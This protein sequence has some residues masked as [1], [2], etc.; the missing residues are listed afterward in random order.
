MTDRSDLAPFLERVV[1]GVGLWVVLLGFVGSVIAWIGAWIPVVGFTTAL[2]SAAVAARLAARLPAPTGRPLGPV[3]AG[4]LVVGVLAVTVWTGVTHSEQVLPRR[5]SASYLQATI[6]LAEEG[7]RPVSVDAGT[8]GGPETLAE[9]GLTLEAPAFYE[10]GSPE[11]PQVQPQFMPGPALVYSLPWW[12]GGATPTLWT[13]AVAGGLAL[14]AVGMLVAR[15]VGPSAAAPA[16]VLVGACFPWLHT[17]RSTY[18]EPLAGLTLGAGFLA[19]TLLARSAEQRTGGE[20]TWGT[21][22]VVAGALIGG[23]AI[24]R[25]DALRETMLLIPV[26]ALLLARGRAWARPLLVGAVGTTLAGFAV[27]GVMSWRYLGEIGSSLVPLVALVVLMSLVCWWL[28][29]RARAGWSVPRPLTQRLP[30]LLAGAVLVVGVALSLRPLFMTV[31]QDPSDPGAMYVA[32]MQ[33][34]LGLPIDGGRTYAEHSVDWLAWWIGPAALVIALV[35]LAVLAHRLGTW[36]AKGGPLPAWGPALIVVTGSTLLTLVRPGIT[37]DH[38]WADRRLLIALPLALVL[39]V[40]AAWWAGGQASRRWG[41]AAGAAVLV[42]LL[43][44]TAVPTAAATWPHRTERV[45]QGGLAA[46][47]TY[48]DA[49]G[50]D[51]VVLAVDDWAVNHWTQVTRG[52]CGVPAIA[53]TGRLRDD[54]D[55]V[56]A[57]AQR[58]DERVRAQGGRVLLVAHREPATLEELGATDVRTVLDTVLMEDPHVLTERPERLDP[59]RL[60]VWTGRVPR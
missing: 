25:I 45:E 37:P 12:A 14:L 57:A 35:A 5:D 40:A 26:A 4:A 24:V 56:L 17:A 3:A 43:A 27:A 55:R 20:R 29:R 41:S 18:S 2:V 16:A 30:S 36:W 46:A 7:S 60:T 21:A 44:A 23:T 42:A 9:D 47:A 38:P 8:I 52:M 58:L 15:V 13:P 1:V 48:C 39:A 6:L 28:L 10:I 53:T 54:P 49:L 11:D 22:A 51:D 33:A 19:L 31:R 59:L 34:Q 50:P 32:R